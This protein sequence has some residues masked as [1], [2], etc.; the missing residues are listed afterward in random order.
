MECPAEFL[1]EPRVHDTG[2]IEVPAVVSDLLCDLGNQPLKSD[3]LTASRAGEDRVAT[4]NRLRVVLVAAW[5]LHDGWFVERRVGPRALPLLQEGLDEMA[6]VVPADRCVSDPDRREELVRTCLLGLGLRP[7]GE[8]ADVAQD[9]LTTLSSAERARVVQ[10]ARAAEE[11][12][13]KVR[14]E[15]ARKAAAEAA[16]A[17]APE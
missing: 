16:A 15:L 12:A 14:E 4:R 7:A 3:T 13:R 6:R 11:R 9:R 17:Y 1:A 10:A 2:V 8:T 5:L